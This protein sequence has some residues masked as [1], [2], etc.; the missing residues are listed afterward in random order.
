[1]AARV[2]TPIPDLS[3]VSQPA[4]SP[5]SPR[6]E[7]L[8]DLVGYGVHADLLLPLLAVEEHALDLAR[9]V[10]AADAHAHQ[11]HWQVPGRETVTE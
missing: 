5:Q 2:K 1:M 7:P 4:T 6:S 10:Q 3:T 9:V 11:P 8:F